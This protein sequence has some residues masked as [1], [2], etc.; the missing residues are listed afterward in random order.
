[1]F[2]ASVALGAP[3]WKLTRKADTVMF[4]LSKGLG[5]P[6]GSLLVG[7]ADVIDR[8]RLYRKALGGGMR[9]AGIL[10]AAGLIALEQ[11]PAKLANDHGNAKFL[12]QA[13]AQI[14]GFK[15][16]PAD[17]QT[18]IVISDITGT[19]MTSRELSTLLRRHG[20][21]ADGVGPDQLRFVTHLDVN[22]QQCERAVEM[23]A[24][25]LGAKATP[26]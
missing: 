17:V 22:R 5:A 7:K 2:N 24:S 21:L 9:Q 16:N 18:N 6:V 15:I 12:A 4:C 23:V 10:A 26:A 25:A 19:G 13:V 20:V 3:V 1:V 11:N 14:P 8:G